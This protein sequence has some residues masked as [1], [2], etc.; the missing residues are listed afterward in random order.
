MTNNTTSL[1]QNGLEQK[2]SLKCSSPKQVRFIEAVMAS[3]FSIIRKT[4]VDNSST[5]H[6]GTRSYRRE[7]S[8]LTVKDVDFNFKTT[9]PN[10]SYKE[11]AH[12]DGE[13]VVRVSDLN[14]TAFQPNNAYE[15]TEEINYIRPAMSPPPPYQEEENGYVQMGPR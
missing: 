10:P 14:K 12:Q 8:T 5:L 2:Q 6:Q 15:N 11:S 9:F 4:K 3:F 7:R 1:L 13:E